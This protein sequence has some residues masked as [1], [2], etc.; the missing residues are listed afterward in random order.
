MSLSSASGRLKANIMASTGAFIAHVNPSQRD[1]SSFSHSRHNWPSNGEIKHLSST[2][3]QRLSSIEPI[4]TY[5]ATYLNWPHAP[6]NSGAILRQV[7]FV[8]RSV[9]LPVKYNLEEQSGISR[10]EFTTAWLRSLD[11]RIEWA[12]APTCQGTYLWIG[13]ILK[14]FSNVTEWQ[15]YRSCPVPILRQ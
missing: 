5:M 13:K 15:A 4:L 7:I 11:A 10:S 14:I 1:G 9:R 3:L 12:S 6:W 2:I 8:N